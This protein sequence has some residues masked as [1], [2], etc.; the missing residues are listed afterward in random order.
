MEKRK[1]WKVMKRMVYIEMKGSVEQKNAAS[2]CAALIHTQLSQVI[3]LLQC[4]GTDYSTSA[5][6]IGGDIEESQ[7]ER[8]LP[9]TQTTAHI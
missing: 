4:L 6:F 8:P 9:C 7:L 3:Y 1:E 5:V 2:L